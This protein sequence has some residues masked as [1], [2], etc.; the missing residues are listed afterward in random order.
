[1]PS[2]TPFVIV[3]ATPL[4]PWTGNVNAAGYAL[5]NLG[6]ITPNGGASSIPISSATTGVYWG[7]QLSGVSKGYIGYTPLGSGGI[8]VLDSSGSTARILIDASGHVGI[9]TATPGYTLDV[10]GTIRTTASDSPP[11]SGAGIEMYY[12][13]GVGYVFPYDRGAS[14]GKDLVLGAAGGGL[15]VTA[16]GGLALTSL[17][18]SNPGAGTKQFWYDPSDSNRVKFAS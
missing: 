7:F 6:A 17:P 13:G 1:M 9:A 10:N 14:A 11:A 3:N 15:R 18:S 4:S 8:A 5:Q 12:S 16:S 2:Q